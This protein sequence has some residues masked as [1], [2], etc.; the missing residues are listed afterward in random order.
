VQKAIQSTSSSSTAWVKHERILVRMHMVGSHVD[1]ML[2][3][4]Q[5]GSK[6]TSNIGAISSQCCHALQ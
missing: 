5:Y 6:D 1:A 4:L 3:G 2:A